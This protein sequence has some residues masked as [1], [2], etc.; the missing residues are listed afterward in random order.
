MQLMLTFVMNIAMMLRLGKTLLLLAFMAFVAQETYAG[1]EH[2]RRAGAAFSESFLD[3]MQ[4]FYN[5]AATAPD[6]VLKCLKDTPTDDSLAQNTL[7]YLKYNLQKARALLAKGMPYQSARFYNVALQIA[8]TSHDDDLQQLILAESALSYCQNNQFKEARQIMQ[9]IDRSSTRKTD[10]LLVSLIAYAKGLLSESENKLGLAIGHYTTAQFYSGSVWPLDIQSQLA[11]AIILTHHDPG[12]ASEAIESILK[13]TDQHTRISFVVSPQLIKLAML[14]HQSGEIQIAIQWLDYI[15]NLARTSSDSASFLVAT[16]HL[17]RIL[18]EQSE[19]DQALQLVREMEPVITCFSGMQSSIFALQT[20]TMLIQ[21]YGDDLRALDLY[22]NYLTNRQQFTRSIHDLMPPPG[23]VYTNTENHGQTHWKYLVLTVALALATFLAGAWAGFR[24]AQ[25]KLR[26]KSVNQPKTLPDEPSEKVFSTEVALLKIKS[27]P[28][29]T[30]FIPFGSGIK[31]FSESDRCKIGLAPAAPDGS[32]SIHIALKASDEIIMAEIEAKPGAASVET[33][34]PLMA[35][36]HELDAAHANASPATRRDSLLFKGIFDT[37]P[38]PIFIKDPE[39]KLV[40]VNRSFCEIIGHPHDYLIGKTDFDLY[41]SHMARLYAASDR[42]VLNEKKHVYEATPFINPKNQVVTYLI[43]KSLYYDLEHDTKYI[44]GLMHDISYRDN[45]E[46]ELRN[47]KEQAEEATRSK[48][49]FLASMSHEIRTP[50]NAIIGMSELLEET[51][52]DEEQTEFVQVISG[53]G[54]KLLDLI[55]DILDLSKIEAGQIRL[56]NNAFDLKDFLFEIEKLFSYAFREKGLQYISEIDPGVPMTLVADELRLRQIVINLINNALKFTHKGNIK[57]TVKQIGSHVEFCI[58]DTGIGMKP[59]E[60]P[61]LFQPFRQVG[62]ES[63]KYKG[64]GLGLAISKQLVNMMQGTIRVE[65]EPG[66]G[67]RFIFTIP[68]IEAEEENSD[69]GMLT[70]ADTPSQ[71]PDRPLQILIAEDNPN[72]Q[73]LLLV[74]L[75]KTNHSYEIATNGKVA[76]EKFKEKPFDIV[77]M[78]IQMPIMDG[79]AAARAIRTYE[80]HS[81]NP[82]RT[83]IIAVT[84]I[85]DEKEITSDFDDFLQKPYKAADITRVL[86]LAD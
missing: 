55:N 21:K 25:R 18:S 60:L 1:S 29:Q 41:P 65:S 15:R 85:A 44:V 72:N 78:D 75:K 86:N 48:S 28:G 8:T 81:G 66:Q 61:K 5:R 26:K 76:V 7:F 30:Q 2:T 32:F 84:A 27:L 53:A 45:I 20:S 14:Y 3:G 57:L 56:K 23:I 63:Q 10:S 22:K 36:A 33:S 54:R 38:N 39:H 50:M 12:G 69:L 42:I 31:I 77:L 67:S 59:E 58:A 70:T 4:N 9:F 74:H 46:K 40:F 17:A 52:L 83:R 79:I 43:S 47:A 24:L 16:S 19:V 35:I 73:Q 80:T 62:S 71:K 51:S 34:A 68:L 82:H 37:N 6:S 11:Q 64:T 49:A 13:S